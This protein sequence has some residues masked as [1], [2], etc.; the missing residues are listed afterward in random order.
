MIRADRYYMRDPELVAIGTAE[1]FLFVQ[2]DG[3]VLDLHTQEPARWSRLLQILMTP[4]LGATLRAQLAGP[5]A[6]DPTDL[7]PLRQQNC[8][9]EAPTPAELEARGQRVFTDNRGYHFARRPQGCAHLVVG[10][11]GS[12]V[13]GLMAPVIV[14]LCHSGFPGRIDLILTETAL[15][16]ATRDL[17]EGYG[18]RTWVDAFERRE[19]VHVAHVALARSADCVLVMPASAACCHRLAEG[20]CS[21]L[22]SLTVAATSAPVVIAPAMN[23]GMWNHAAVQGNMQRL[24][25]HGMYVIEPALIFSAAELA[26]G[27]PAMYGGLG[28][29]W[30]GALGVMH[31]LAAAMRHHRDRGRAD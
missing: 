27:S 26:R 17:F 3:S 24:R 9:L 14:S 11:T 6:I 29:F 7:L 28:T 18:I 1:H 13:A 10:L 4:T 19:E 21:D 30:A 22:L 25:D 23:T 15:R 8:L 16:F 20:A 12:I 5:L 31:A 2:A